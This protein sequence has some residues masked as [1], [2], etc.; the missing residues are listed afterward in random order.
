MAD[1]PILEDV[2]VSD[3][4]GFYKLSIN[5]KGVFLVVYPP[6]GNGVSVSA[7]DVTK[8]LQ[9]NNIEDYNYQTFITAI[10]EASGNEIKIADYAI[11]NAEPE[12]RVLVSRDRM[13]ATIQIDKPKNCRPFSLEEVMN[14]IHDAGIV[15]GIA[16][17]SIKKA[18]ERPGLKLVCAQGQNPVNG[19]DAYI[20]YYVDMENKGHPQELEDGRVDFKSL[21]IFTVVRQGEVLAEKISP[22]SGTPGVD[23]LGQPVPPKSGKDIPAP[24]GK[25]VQ[26][27]DGKT[28]IAAMAGQ[29]VFINNK[30]SIVP[31]IEINGDVDLSTGNIEFVGSVIVRGSVQAGFTVKAEENVEIFGTISGGIVEGKTVSVKMG[32]QGMNT[33]Y[34][35]AS[36]DVIANFIENATVYAGRDIIVNDVILHSQINAGNRVIVENR[37]G[38]IVGGQVAAGM[39]I[40]AKVVGNHMAINT[41]LIVGINPSLREE[42]QQLRKNVKKSEITL[43][44]TQKALNIL[45]SMN[46]SIM[47][48]DKKEL[49]L[50]LTKTQFNLTGQIESIKNRIIEIELVF[51]EMHSGSI[52]VSDTLYPGVK[53]IIG[54][55]IKPIREKL[56]FVSLYPEEGEI[57]I[58]FYK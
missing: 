4:D 51:E 18:Y 23:I 7:V 17:D 5:E 26:I 15:F 29:L 13:E 24:A 33:G 30:I 9:K 27:I 53:V 49:M 31:V 41:D 34:V 11:Q 47:P 28:L 21:N 1:E 39:L 25:N 40:R 57:K 2:K 10:K 19:T 43:D 48:P 55:I 22:T 52:K 6:Q 42:Y 56:N 45:R 58:G 35:K 12:I 20:N 37:R 46:Q 44:Q 38:L 16:E 54:T 50:K 14:K 3:I 36:E 32:I 8:E